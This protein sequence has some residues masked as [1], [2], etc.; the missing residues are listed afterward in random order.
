MRTTLNIDG[1]LLKEIQKKTGMKSK[2]QII[3]TALAE[4]LRRLTRKSIKDAYG[5]LHFDDS[6]G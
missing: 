4:Y 3:N 1:M 6:L 5:Q 2:T